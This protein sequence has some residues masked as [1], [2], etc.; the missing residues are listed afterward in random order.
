MARFASLRVK[1]AVVD[2]TILSDD[3]SSTFALVK[4]CR[5]E[6]V[7]IDFLVKAA[8]DEDEGSSGKVEVDVPTGPPVLVGLD[9]RTVLKFDLEHPHEVVDVLRGQLEQRL[10]VR[11][12]ALHVPSVQRSV[13]TFDH[14]HDAGEEM[15]AGQD[16]SGAIL[17]RP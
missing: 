10:P 15:R 7:G 9:H 3:F 5:E 4:N 17:C 6:F 8:V 12:A 1:R 11:T 2:P 16:G 13:A 14:G